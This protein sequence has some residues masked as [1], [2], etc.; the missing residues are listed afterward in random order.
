M[1]DKHLQ[2]AGDTALL[3]SLCRAVE[4]QLVLDPP[5]VF[6]AKLGLKL[7]LYLALAAGS[8]ALLFQEQDPARF[9]LTY[10]VYGVCV[11]LFAFNFAHD[12]A[13]H[14]VFRSARLNHFCFVATYTL[15][16]G[17]GASWK[18]RHIHEHHHAPNVLGQDPDLKT[19]RLIRLIPGSPHLSIHRYQHLYAPLFYTVYTLMWIFVKDVRFLYM[20]EAGS[21]AGAEAGAGSD[22][23]ARKD[24]RY[25]A[26]FWLQ[27]A[28]YLTVI[29]LLPALFSGQTLPTIL[30]GFLLMHVTQ[31]LLL[32]FTFLMTHHVEGTAYPVRDAQGQ[33]H[34]SWLRNQILSS[35][36]VHPFSSV[37]N[38]LLGGFNNHVAHHL[39]PHIHHLYYPRLSRILYGQLAAHGL[40]PLHTTY[41][42]G[43]ASHMRLLRRMG[44]G[45]SPA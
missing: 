40:T 28:L 11:L 9:V 5:R 31:S 37:A 2:D 38:F 44:Q 10:V 30:L 33:I 22:A 20:R 6:A 17:H 14:T 18:Q 45:A 32:L 12:C 8:Y 26:T 15:L 25:H 3:Q 36:D 4:E 7:A 39:F 42:G 16:G 35:N 13:H 29:V 34:T 43:I 23:A 27:K 21:E 19:T 1:R 24:F 41:W